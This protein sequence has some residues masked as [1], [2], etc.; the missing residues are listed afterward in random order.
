[1]PKDKIFDARSIVSLSGEPVSLSGRK[2]EVILQQWFREG[3]PGDLS[4]MPKDKIFD[5]RSIV[6][7]S[8]E[9]VSLSGRKGQ[10]KIEYLLLCDIMAKSISVKAG[11]FN[12]LTV[13][14]FSLLTAVVCGIRMNWASILFNILKKMVSAGSKQAK[15]F[16][17]Q[18]SLLLESIPNLELGESTE[19]PAS[20]IL[21]DK[22]VHRYISFNDKVGVEEAADAPPMKKAPRKPAASKKRPAAATAREPVP[23]KK[24]TSKKKSGSSSSTLE[25]VVVAQE[26]VP[27]Q[28][29]E[30]S[31]G[32]P[33]AEEPVEQPAAEEDIS[34]DQPI[35]KVT[36]EVG[37]EKVAA[38][39]DA[40]ADRD[41]PA[42]T[43]EER[44]WFDLSHEELIAKWAA[45]RLV[46]T[47]DDT[48][49]EIEAERPV[50]KSVAT[51]ES[52][53]EVSEAA[54][55]KEFSFVD[56]PDTVINQVLHQLDSISDDK[57]DNQSDRAE[58]W[59]DRA[60]DE[61]LRNDTDEEA[62][63]VDAGTAGGDQQVQISE[64]EP[65]DKSVD[66]FINADEKLSLEDIPM[67]I[68]ADVILPSA[69]I[70]I[71]KITMGKTIKIPGVDERNWYLDN[72][73][74]IPADDKGNNILVEKDPV[75]GNPAKE[76]YFLICADI[77]LLVNLRAQVIEAVDQ[78]FHSF[79]F[80]KLATINIDELSRKEEQVLIWGETEITHVALSR[81]RGGDA[82]KEEGSSSCPQPH[83]SNV[84]GQGSGGNPG[85]GS[86]PTAVAAIRSDQLEFQ[87]KI[88]TDLLSLSTQIGDL[89]DY[90]RDG[91]AK[92]GEGSSS[93]PQPP[94]PNVQGQ[95]SGPSVVR[96]TDIADRIREDDRRQMKAERE[97]E[98]QRRIRRLSS[99]SHK[100]RRGHQ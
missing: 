67:T 7:L 71:T 5:A 93:H 27:L 41:K 37:V 34:A 64:E 44:Q 49:E 40:S 94:P 25:M 6:S 77:D 91:D 31:T 55:D 36:G 74:K 73:P 10:M 20:K 33:T 12:A 4:D 82:K 79:S 23:K 28:M 19:F 48:D 75:K 26:A 76:H 22:T 78:F 60:F 1:M 100:R 87:A 54:A 70:E 32:V 61:M 9:P 98:R 43:T 45:E 68:P 50:F 62:E 58:T 24:R 35:D 92:K 47:P 65:V 63:T 86:G 90:I 88:S 39:I 21:T 57:A 56:D 16:A 53:V 85:E 15:G 99:G 83:P 69:G 8:G 59:F 18:I 81:K 96:L 46:T 51:V 29:V 2:V 11:Y 38:E 72:L 13:E 89:V 80:K 95:G 30:P 52:V 14:K 84:Q 66:D 42:D 17:V 3:R 97:R